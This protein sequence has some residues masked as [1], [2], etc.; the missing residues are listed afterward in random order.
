M[1]RKIKRGDFML[2]RLVIVFIV[3]ILFSPMTLLAIEKPAFSTKLFAAD[4]E[5]N[6]SA[7]NLGISFLPKRIRM[8][9]DVVLLTD[10]NNNIVGMQLGDNSFSYL[11]RILSRNDEESI[12]S[13]PTL[14]FSLDY[15]KNKV[16]ALY[17][18]VPYLG[19]N[20][21]IAADARGL[22][23]TE[24]GELILKYRSSLI[25]TSKLI[26][27]ITKDNGHW[28]SYIEQ[29]TTS[30]VFD[31]PPSIDF[32]R[33]DSLI[34]RSLLGLA[35]REPRVVFNNTNFTLEPISEQN[36]IKILSTINS[37]EQNINYLIKE[38]DDDNYT[39]L[40]LQLKDSI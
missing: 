13:V 30:P 33:V 11:A 18:H 31:E 6:S 16:F 1:L 4:V 12:E 20:L 5:Y 24:G 39:E 10:K 37:I 7:S 28:I 8:N 35:I 34:L 25:S 14:F 17:L 26:L 27:K 29:T 36:A 3:F 21:I 22:Q 38:R 40:R 2:F 9:V 19:N 15:Y 23:P 32:V